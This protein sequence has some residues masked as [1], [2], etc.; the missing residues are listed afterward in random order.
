MLNGDTSPDWIVQD[1]LELAELWC[2]PRDLETF[3]LA[4][5]ILLGFFLNNV[6]RGFF[7]SFCFTINPCFL[8][9]LF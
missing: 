6:R 8:N 5:E 2:F 4:T 9:R 1:K 3:H 7:L